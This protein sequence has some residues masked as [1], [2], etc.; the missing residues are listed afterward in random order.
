MGAVWSCGVLSSPAACTV[1]GV[2]CLMNAGV[3]VW[4]ANGMGKIECLDL[5]MGKMHTAL[6]GAAGSVTSLAMHPASPLI[7][8]V[9]LDRYLRVHSVASRALLSKV[10]LKQ[11]LAAVTW[12]ECPAQALPPP[13]AQ[14]QA[15]DT[16]ESLQGSHV[17]KPV[18]RR[19]SNA[20]AVEPQSKGDRPRKKKR[21]S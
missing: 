8:S 16:V 11:Q 10:Y 13:P 6:K 20:R 1:T 9:G 18:A 5:R 3:S 12:A 14:S 17:E 7:A 21:G 15:E 2:I 19:K 4:A